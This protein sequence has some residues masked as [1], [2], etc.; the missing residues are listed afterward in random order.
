MHPTGFWKRWRSSVKNKQKSLKLKWS[1]NSTD[2]NGEKKTKTSSSEPSARLSPGHRTVG[3]GAATCAHILAPVLR[4]L[5]IYRGKRKPT[6]FRPSARREPQRA[7]GAAPGA[8][9]RA[10][11]KTTKLCRREVL[12]KGKTSVKTLRWLTHWWVRKP[13]DWGLELNQLVTC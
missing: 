6:R 8:R 9:M 1:C 11:L 5:R 12:G 7:P 13:R 4:Q 2:L 3:T 10:L